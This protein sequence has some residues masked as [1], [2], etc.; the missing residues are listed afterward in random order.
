MLPNFAK[1]HIRRGIQTL[2][3]ALVHLRQARPALDRLPQRI[4]NLG[5]EIDT[6]REDES[7]RFIQE[8]IEGILA[9]DSLE[10]LV[11]RPRRLRIGWSG[12]THLTRGSSLALGWRHR[13]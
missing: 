13:L 2:G 10:S 8:L 5:N 3:A 7:V 9:H 1:G 12:G 4:G 6:L 11:L